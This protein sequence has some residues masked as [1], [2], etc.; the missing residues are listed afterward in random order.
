[1]QRT[2]YILSYIVFACFH[3]A[4]A[5][6]DCRDERSAYRRLCDRLR[7]DVSSHRSRSSSAMFRRTSRRPPDEIVS[8]LYRY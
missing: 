1:M 8:Y 3:V 4:S 5:V 7:D 6:E 2:L